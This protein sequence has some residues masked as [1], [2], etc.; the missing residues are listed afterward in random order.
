[1]LFACV[2]ARAAQTIR[3]SATEIDTPS[4]YPSVRGGFGGS[5]DFEGVAVGDFN[6]DGNSDLALVT[7]TQGGAESNF[8]NTA[9]IL[10]QFGNGDGTF[11]RGP[12][13]SLNAPTPQSIGVADFNG[14][15]NQDLAL[16]NA[17][18]FISV[19]LGNGDGT[20]QPEI[21]VAMP[22]FY[23]SSLVV[24]DFNRDGKSDIAVGDFMIAVLLGKEDGTFQ[25]PVTYK[26]AAIF[27]SW[28]TSSGDFNGD[29]NIDLVIGGTSISKDNCVSL[30]LGKGDG[31]FQ[32]AVALATGISHTYATS[33]AVGDFNGDGKLDVAV[34]TPGIDGFMLPGNGNG[35]FGPAQFL[36]FDPRYPPNYTPFPSMVAADFDGDGKLDLVATSSGWI[37]LSVSR[38]KGDGT[39]YAPAYVHAM[40]PLHLAV[41]DFN[42]DGKPDLAASLSVTNYM[43]VSVLINTAG[44]P[45]PR[46]IS[47]IAEGSGWRT[48]VILLNT[49]DE[50]AHFSLAFRSDGT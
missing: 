45:V 50:A 21:R 33:G 34:T 36:T 40:S 14:D 18:Q 3:F 9:V 47:H 24:G 26:L 41:G 7:G 6:G 19:L 43:S 30:L 35:T 8:A 46:T 25:A 27:R 1:M 48:T 15:G 22:G 2:S 32:P 5:N 42:K 13:F 37:G 12:L 28:W 44:A 17:G 10:I 11:H 16:V 39:F 29:G 38:G 4:K 23:F 31:T 49:G 20:F